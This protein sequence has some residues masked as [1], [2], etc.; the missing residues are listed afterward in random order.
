MFYDDYMYPGIYPHDLAE[1]GDPADLCMFKARPRSA[2]G[3]GT[4]WQL[5]RAVAGHTVSRRR[6]SRQS[7]RVPGRLFRSR[8]AH[9]RSS[10]DRS[11][12]TLGLFAQSEHQLHD[13]LRVTA[14]LRY[15]RYFDSFGYVQSARRA[16]LQPERQRR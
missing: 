12:D 9:V 1:P 4:E 8:A 6:I 7:S 11:S 2:G 16:D 15:D 3:L 13:N 10:D 14:G 5:T